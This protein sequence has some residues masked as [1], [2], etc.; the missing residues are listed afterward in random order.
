VAHAGH[1]DASGDGG[2]GVEADWLSLATAR[3]LRVC[4]A[5]APPLP[6]EGTAA[7]HERD[8]AAGRTGA[9]SARAWEVPS[10]GPP[11]SPAHKGLMD[12]PTRVVGALL[13][14]VF[15]RKHEGG[16]SSRSP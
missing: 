10:V 11:G 2:G 6:N 16:A 12:H 13:K 1:R 4:I 14:Q 3:R 7:E 8:A 15:A 5:A 9:G